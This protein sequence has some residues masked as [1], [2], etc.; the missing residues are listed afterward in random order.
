MWYLIQR[1]AVRPREDW[2]V[3][4][5]THLDWMKRQHEAGRILFSGPTPDRKTGIYVI[6][7]ESRQ[8]AER[9]AASDPFTAAGFCTFDL[10]EWDVHQV[11]G[12]G[13]FTAAELQR[14]RK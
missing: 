4:L 1:R 8:E 13:P 11:M 10:T 3:S 2:T 5:D 6:R 12:I 9:I 14:H 7:A